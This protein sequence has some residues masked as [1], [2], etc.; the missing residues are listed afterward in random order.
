M[1]LKIPFCKDFTCILVL[2]NLMVFIT[3][4]AF[5]YTTLQTNKEINS[6]KSEILINREYTRHNAFV[7]DS[8]LEAHH[9]KTHPEDTLKKT[10]R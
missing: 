1:K 3:F 5:V 4:F 6:I 2:L 8:V 9:A 10:G 7:L